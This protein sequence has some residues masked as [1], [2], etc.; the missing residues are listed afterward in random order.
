MA[1]RR[2]GVSLE[3]KLLKKLDLFSREHKFS[4]RSQAIRFLIQEHC[5]D[6]K[7][8]KDGIVAGCV[9]L[10]YDYHKREVVDKSIDIQHKYHNL[11]LSSQHI[12]LSHNECLELIALKGRASKI[13]ELADALIALKGVQHGRLVAS[14]ID[15]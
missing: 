14:G 12:H 1:V 13:K 4:N 3:G 6:R 8:E 9:V 15:F 7:W 2:F 10:V 5:V 11:V